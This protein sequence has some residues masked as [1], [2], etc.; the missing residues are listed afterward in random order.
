MTV[1]TLWAILLPWAPKDGA[2]LELAQREITALFNIHGIA[3]CPSKRWESP[4]RLSGPPNPTP[5]I[6]T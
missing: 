5:G 6:V 1:I 3:V 4:V 2:F